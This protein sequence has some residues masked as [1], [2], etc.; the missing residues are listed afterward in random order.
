MA[1][2]DA[3]AHGLAWILRDAARAEAT[4]SLYAWLP[5]WCD[6]F[7]ALQV[8]GFRVHPTTRVLVG[9]SYD[10]RWAP[11]WYAENWFMTLGDTDLV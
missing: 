11:E 10:K 9:R 1:G 5:T 4:S 8:A 3:P 6:D 2:V 7:L